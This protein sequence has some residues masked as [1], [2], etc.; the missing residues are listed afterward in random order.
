MKI[1]TVLVMCGSSIATST[2]AAAKI[3]KEAKS[4]GV[5]VNV[6]KGRVSDVDRLM[7]SSPVDLVVATAVFRHNY[8]VPI[9]SG[10]PLITGVGQRDLYDKIFEIVRKAS[11]E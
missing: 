3:E 9:L 5:Q 6:M 11:E 4:R 8:D 1:P 7:K 2:L 10:V